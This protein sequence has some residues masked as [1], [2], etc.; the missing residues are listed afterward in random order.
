MNPRYILSDYRNINFLNLMLNIQN[1]IPVAT[2]HQNSKL[3]TLVFEIEKLN[4]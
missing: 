4:R 2:V 3:W 1:E